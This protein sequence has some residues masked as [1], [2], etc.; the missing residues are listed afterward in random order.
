MEYANL[1]GLG[2][3]FLYFLFLLRERKRNKLKIL[4]TVGTK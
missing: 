4:P 2:G 1:I 3:V